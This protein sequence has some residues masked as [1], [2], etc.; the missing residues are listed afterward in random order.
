MLEHSKAFS[1][2]SVDDIPTAKQFYGETLGLHV[3]EEYGMLRLHLAGDRDTLIYPKQ[4]HTPAT[5]T[6]LN[7]PVDSIEQAVDALSRKG[8]TFERYDNLTDERGIARGLANN[9]GPDIAWFKDPA[10]NILSILQE[11]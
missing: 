6:I 8:V 3:S 10:G 7:F 2:F 1:G 9:R 4:D 5:Y 11:A